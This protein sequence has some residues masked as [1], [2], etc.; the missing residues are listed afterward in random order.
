MS[1]FT[2]SKTGL[3]LQGVVRECKPR[4]TVSE[5]NMY[6]FHNCTLKE[7]D[8]RSFFVIFKGFEITCLAC[9]HS[10]KFTSQA[11]LEKYQAAQP[12]F[13]PW[14]FSYLPGKEEVPGSNPGGAA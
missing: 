8:S 10:R 3:N 4:H 6:K 9:L 1:H 7:T 13:E 12:G 5:P 14:T 11:K 2:F